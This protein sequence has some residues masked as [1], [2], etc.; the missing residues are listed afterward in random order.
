MEENAQNMRV[1]LSLF[2]GPLDLLLHLIK[3]N[4]L[5]IYNIPIALILDQYLEY[6]ELMKE[7][8]IDLAGEF[9]L[10]AAEMAH[11]KSRSLVHQPE[12]EE[13]EEADPRAD[14][15]ARLVE[16]QRYKRA[17]SWLDSRPLLARNV[18]KRPE[19]LQKEDEE[20]AL[21]TVEAEPLAVDPFNLLKAFQEILKK[22]PKEI[23]HQVEAERMSVTE[24]I[25]EILENLR[26]TESVPFASLFTFDTTRPRLV[27]TFLAL[28]EMARLQ[29][30]FI[31]QMESFGDIWIKRK[32]EISDA[33]IKA[34]V[35]TTSDQPET[36][37]SGTGKTGEHYGQNQ[38]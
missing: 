1:N 3:K 7:L 9:L 15:V 23:R 21:G 31:H 5:D 24:R 8:D 10:L 25:Y 33:V 11:I 38:S 22:I 36:D 29:M 35:R 20:A 34:P 17:A 12:E 4:D 27:V 13:G 32:M 2:E 30:I 19:A 18:F 26:E 16:Y 37:Q 14:L 28:L 6:L